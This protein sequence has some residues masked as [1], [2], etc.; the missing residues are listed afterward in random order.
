M[1]KNGRRPAADRSIPPDDGNASAGTRAAG[2]PA[3]A[4]GDRPHPIRRLYDW[5]LGW[6]ETP[7]G[8]A[9]L[10]LLA[11]AESSFFPVPPDVL[12]IALAISIP[13]KSF[14][15]AT[16]AL[17]GSVLGGVA[18]YAIG[19]GLWRALGVPTDPVSLEEGI[20]GGA[21]LFKY[22]PG[23]TPRVFLRVREAYQHWESLTVF[24]AAFTPIP[25]KVITIGAGVCRIHFGWFVFW[26]FL[27]RGARFFL[28]AALIRRFGPPVRAFIEKYFN[29]LTLLFLILLI[30]GFV[31]VRYGGAILEA[32]KALFR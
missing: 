11:F 32:V 24:G 19:W 6:A 1:L 9:A 26:S 16:I 14:R 17:A 4:D 25:Y 21:L 30:G 31:V 2:R 22:V 8:P 20:L 12:L 29:L 13:R 7:Y 10:F 18:G 23:F 15:Y 3:S 27:G 5:V 28:V